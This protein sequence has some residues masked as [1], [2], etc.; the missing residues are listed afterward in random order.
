M[1]NITAHGNLGKDPEL[2]EVK[3]TQIAE[4]SLAANTGKD[5]TTWINCVV[6]GK[7]ADTVMEYLHKGD[8]ITVAGSGQL[9]EYIRSKDNSKGYSLQLRVSDF[10]LPPKTDK[11]GADF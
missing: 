6:W 5:E 2:K 4:F 8:K 3:D 9:K 1:L 11:S 10:T 7:R